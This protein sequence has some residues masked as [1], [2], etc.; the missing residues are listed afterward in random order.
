MLKKISITEKQLKIY[1]IILFI[2]STGIYFLLSNHIKVL[3]VYYDELRYYGFARNFANGKGLFLYNIPYTDQKILYD[4]FLIPAFWISDKF[5]QL[6]AIALINSILVTSGIFPIYIL[7]KRII[8][9]NF[10]LLLCLI[11]YCF[12]SD[13][14]FSQTFMSENLFIPLALWGI[15]LYDGLFYKTKNKFY[16]ISVGIFTYALYMTKEISIVFL[17][18]WLLIILIKMINNGIKNS[19]E[20]I[21]QFSIITITFGILFFLVQ[22]TI[23]KGM[24]NTY[25]SQIQNVFAV[26]GGIRYVLYACFIYFANIMISILFVP[27]IIPIL[28]YNSLNDKQKNLFYLLVFLAISSI[29]I[30]TYTWSFIENFGDEIPRTH[31]RYFGYLYIPFIVLFYSIIEKKEEKCKNIKKNL[32]HIV[33][34]LILVILTIIFFKSPKNDS[35]LDHSVLNWVYVIAYNKINFIK[36]AMIIFLTTVIIVFYRNNSKSNLIIG[37][38]FFIIFLGLEIVNSR[39]IINVNNRTHI[40]KS[41]ALEVIE[42]NKYINKNLDKNFL[43][44][45]ESLND[46]QR[47][48]DTYMYAPNVYAVYEASYVGEQENNGVDLSKKQLKS[49]I[50]NVPYYNLSKIDY[51]IYPNKLSKKFKQKNIEY[52]TKL[53][54]GTFSVLKLKNNKLLP[55]LTESLLGLQFYGDGAFWE[56]GTVKIPTNGVLY[57]PYIDLPIGKY[58]VE[59]TCEFPKGAI[60]EFSVLKEAE[61]PNNYITSISSNEKTVVIEFELKEKAHKV[62]FTVR[63]RN[64][65]SFAVEDIQLHRIE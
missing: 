60:G 62:E 15:V 31:L 61:V 43:I 44:I 17:I 39:E 10:N 12:F 51:I 6:S 23:F 58:R 42:I 45:N 64:K 30:V 53:D 40:S 19:K 1:G 24:E 14:N 33:I 59:F 57:G 25:G 18:A 52:V 65:F 9:N 38:L 21:I 26:K 20:E 54:F 56:K 4:I 34:V 46:Y 36:C 48:L 41:Q 47:I 49:L 37:M 28:N 35:G 3:Y 2:I 50:N 13:L 55:K 32:F 27:I 7:G 11:L 22:N 16:S 63:N 5:R 8:K 29:G